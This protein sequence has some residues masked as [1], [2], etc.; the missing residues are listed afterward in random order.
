M[1]ETTDLLI[2]IL[3]TNLA[4]YFNSM[5]QVNK[6]KSFRKNSRGAWNEKCVNSRN[7]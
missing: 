7:L 2:S 5:R 6:E 3:G 4:S 1:A